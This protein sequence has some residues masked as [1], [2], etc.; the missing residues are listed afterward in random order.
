MNEKV[1]YNHNWLIIV[2]D[3]ILKLDL[4]RFRPSAI[5]QALYVTTCPTTYVLSLNTC[6]QDNMCDKTNTIFILW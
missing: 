4:G 1:H 3:G 5:N 6:F 2:S